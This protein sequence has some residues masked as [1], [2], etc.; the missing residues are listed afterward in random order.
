MDGITQCLAFLKSPPV[1]TQNEPLFPFRL[2]S[3][4]PPGLREQLLA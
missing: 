4:V 2:T 3:L 1:S